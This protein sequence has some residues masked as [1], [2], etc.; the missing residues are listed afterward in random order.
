MTETS[1]GGLVT[2]ADGQ[3]REILSFIDQRVF[4]EAPRWRGDCL[5]ASDI[6]GDEILRIQMSGEYEVVAG[7]DRPSGLGWLAD[8]RLIVN[9]MQER[10]VFRIEPDGQVVLHAD[11][12]EVVAFRINDMVTDTQGRAYVGQGVLTTATEEYQP[13]PLVRVDPDGTVQAVGDGLM[14]ANGIVLSEDGATLI[15]AETKADRLSAFDVL[16]DGTLAN[17]RVW[18]E[19]KIAHPDGICLDVEGAIWVASFDNSCFVRVREGGEVLDVIETPDRRA[20]ACA[21]GGSDGRTLFMIT[22]RVIGERD[23]MRAARASQIE[24]T[25]VEVPGCERP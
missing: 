15:V 24:L 22:A 18:A 16:P 10:K 17:R 4:L 20:V 1:P 19:L 3:G 5:Y 2:K 11:C 7:L 21:L 9:S 8:G 14:V 12:T 25:R 23:S 13:T 6:H